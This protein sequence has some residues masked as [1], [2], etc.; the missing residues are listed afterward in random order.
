ME[1]PNDYACCHSRG[2]SPG[3][4]LVVLSYLSLT[5]QG[6]KIVVKSDKWVEYASDV[7]V[8]MHISFSH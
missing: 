4:I 3:H 7:I 2:K 8:Y 5:A 6:S 1:L